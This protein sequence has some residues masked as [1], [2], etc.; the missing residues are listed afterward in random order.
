[1][2]ESAGGIE[3][4]SKGVRCR[5]SWAM[6]IRSLTYAHRSVCYLR[7]WRDDRVP[8]G[9]MVVSERE[10]GSRLNR[11]E[12]E[13]GRQ[14]VVARIKGQAG[15]CGKHLVVGG[16]RNQAVKIDRE[17]RVVRS[18]ENMMDM[19]IS[20][21]A[22]R[23]TF[24]VS[25]TQGGVSRGLRFNSSAHIQEVDELV[26]VN[27]RRAANKQGT[28]LTLP[29]QGLKPF[30]AHV[31]LF[32]QEPSEFADWPCQSAMVKRPQAPTSGHLGQHDLLLPQS[33]FQPGGATDPSASAKVSSAMRSMFA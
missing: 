23:D 10:M 13:E 5:N 9:S 26:D 11:D 15:D 24:F 4:F 27:R 28:M 30:Q 25:R 29:L 3:A 1:M 14:S 12:V 21:R 31:I 16:F 8:D 20:H 6:L 33:F 2:P 22:H 32:C 17:R 19:S 7:L 18:L